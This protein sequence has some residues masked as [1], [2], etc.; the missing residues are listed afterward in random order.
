[1]K[2]KVLF[3]IAGLLFNAGCVCDSPTP[4]AATSGGYCHSDRHTRPNVYSR[5]NGDADCH[6]HADSHRAAHG[7]RD[8][9]RAQRLT[10]PVAQRG[11]PCGV[12]DLLDFP[13]GAPDGQDASARWPFGRYSERYK[14]IHA[15]EDWV[16]DFGSSLGKPVYTIGHG[17][18]LY[19][20]PWGWGGDKGTIIIRHVFADGSTIMSFYGHLDPPS[21]VLARRSTV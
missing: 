7:H 19:A 13:L 1:M 15:G 17:Q 18:V 14:G 10:T 5:A 12:V 4:T 3:G 16:Y 11:A 21:V 9:L 20:E 2:T 6:A 8:D